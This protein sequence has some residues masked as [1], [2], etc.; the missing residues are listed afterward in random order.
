MSGFAPD[1]LARALKCGHYLRTPADAECP[2][3]VWLL[4]P[5]RRRHVTALDKAGA[6]HADLEDDEREPD[7]DDEA[8]DPVGDATMFDWTPDWRPWAFLPSEADVSAT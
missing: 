6:E 7:A 1:L 4:I 5:L 3:G 8:T 2:S